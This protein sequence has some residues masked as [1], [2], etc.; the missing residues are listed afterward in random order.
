[1]KTNAKKK[2]A[3]KNKRQIDFKSSCLMVQAHFKLSKSHSDEGKKKV[4][5]WWGGGG[6]EGAVHDG[7]RPAVSHE[8]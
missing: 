8:K 4:S 2:T 3:K 1:M 6:R 7:Q 5:V